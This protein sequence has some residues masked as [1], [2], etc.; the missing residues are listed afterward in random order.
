[1]ALDGGGTAR[2]TSA[3][4]PFDVEVSG[5]VRN[6]EPE[7]APREGPDVVEGWR[8]K[9]LKAAQT[10][11]RNLPACV[12]ALRRKDG[13]STLARTML[14]GAHMLPWVHEHD[15]RRFEVE[16]RK[17]RWALP[18]A[19]R[20]KTFV[21]EDHP[22]LA[23]ARRFSSYVTR[24]EGGAAV[25]A[26]ITMNAPLRHKG[27]TLYQSGWGPEDA[28]PGERLFST[29]S[30]VRNPTDQVPLIACLVIAAGLLFQFGRKL[31]LHVRREADRRADPR[32][33]VGSPA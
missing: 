32:S 15:G 24:L 6:A 17:V 20:L 19:V 11:E 13:G 3:R 21:K 12:A 7:R 23:M 26:H 22:G 10:A 2:F 16:L 5:W 18:F 8:A 29:F 33:A 4:L 31:Y 1:M 30:V 28:R 27:Y 9:R 14:W 25:D